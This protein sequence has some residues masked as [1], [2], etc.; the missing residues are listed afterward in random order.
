MK[1]IFSGNNLLEDHRQK[2]P[3]LVNKAYFNFGGQGPMPQGAL[4]AIYRSYQFI[5]S[6][7]PFSEAVYAWEVEEANQTR[8][9]IASEL[10]VKAQTIALTEDVTVGCNIAL[11]GIDW[12]AGDRIL[13]SDC[14]H[15]GIV[16]T[17]GEIQRRFGVEVDICNLMPTLNEGD[18]IDAIARSLRSNTK[19]VV[20]SHILWNTGQVLPLAEI[21]K[22]CQQNSSSTKILVD[23]AQS[24]GMMP[25][26]LAELGVDFYAFTGHKWWC[27]PEGLG[28]LYVRSEAL[29]SLHP[30]FIGWRSF[31]HTNEGIAWH[32]DGRRFEIATSAY[33]LYAGLRTAIAIHHQVGNTRE[34]Y[35]QILQLSKYLWEKLA[36]R[37]HIT[38]LRTSPPE[39]GLVSF[40]I[41][42]NNH[43]QLVHF[44]EKEG[45]FI[46]TIRQPDCVRACVHYFTTQTEIDRLVET[47]EKFNLN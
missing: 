27:G 21:T 6:R 42:N 16:A 30:T 35:Q 38:C 39:S 15:P 45:F 33:P 17:I 37:P 2:F 7:G 34:R 8:E 22:V 9:A 20:L 32:P 47:I 28:G 36:Q 4:D 18:P 44:L 26:N 13:I 24:V 41:A 12:Q 14:E 3:G 43:R 46:R 5:Q 31:F 11:W 25:L 23:A 40:Q 1:N 29:E 10:G 19:L